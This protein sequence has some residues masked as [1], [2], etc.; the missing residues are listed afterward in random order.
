MTFE[1]W[2]VGHYLFIFSPFIFTFFLYYLTKNKSKDAQYKLGIIFSWIAIGILIARNLEIFVKL[3]FKLDAELIPLQICHF[4]NI[5]LLLAFLKR[6][7]SL[8]TLAF[9]FNLP[10]AFLSIVFANSLTNYTTI[11]SAQ[12][13]AYIFGHM[14][15][16]GLTLW[17]FLLRL[18]VI[19]KKVL[20]QTLALLGIL[21]TSA[22]VINN[23]LSLTGLAPNYFYALRPENGTP[24]ELFYNLGKTYHFGF[25]EINPLYLFLTLLLGLFVVFIFYGIY[26]LYNLPYVRKSRLT[27]SSS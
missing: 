20:G 18:F 9:C 14:L 11:L 7:N 24:L 16:V 25:F 1:M 26:L 21:F 15:I 27:H 13:L 19:N 22:I 12:G 3:G 5:V 6:N 17:S 4:A 10:A 8:F 23:L 2:S